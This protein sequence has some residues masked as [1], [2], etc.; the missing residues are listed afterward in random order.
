MAPGVSRSPI[1]DQVWEHVR[2]EF[3]LPTLEQVRGRLAELH[4][5]PETVKRQL[6]RA[7]IDDG[8]YCPDSRSCQARHATVVALF[9]QAIGRRIAHNYFA[10]W[11]ITP[12]PAR[13]GAR[14]VDLPAA[15]PAFSPNCGLGT[16]SGEGC[17]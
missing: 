3:A 17:T 2:S 12:C 16:G 7:F 9:Q 4:E 10:A 13:Q 14:P 11:M 5:D 8:T 1:P 6:V 15:A